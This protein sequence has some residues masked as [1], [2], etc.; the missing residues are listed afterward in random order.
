MSAPTPR[1]APPATVP[2]SFQ[3][4]MVQIISDIGASG[5][6]RAV[7]RFEAPLDEGV[8][9]R[10]V[11]LLYDQEPVL[12]CR[13]DATVSPP[14]WRRHDD[15]DALA[16]VE[17]LETD[18]ET[19]ALGRD[20]GRALPAARSWP[21]AC[22]PARHRDPDGRWRHAGPDDEPCAGGRDGA[23]R[24]L[25]EDRQALYASSGRARLSARGQHGQP[26]Q[27]RL[28]AVVP[29]AR[30]SG[31]AEGGC[32]G[33]TP[34]PR[35]FLGHPQRLGELPGEAGAGAA[36]P[37][38]ASDRA[39]PVACDRPLRPRPPG[40][41]QRRADGRLL[42]RLCGDL[43]PAARRQAR[44]DGADQH[45][46][47]CAAAGGARD[48]QPRQRH[49]YDHRQR[50]R[51][52]LRGYAPPRRRGDEAAQ[53]APARDRV[54]APPAPAPPPALRVESCPD[55]Q[56]AAQ[57]AGAAEP[58]HDDQ[59]RP[60]PSGERAFRRSRA[61]HRARADGG[62]AIADLPR[63]RAPDG[64]PSGPGAGL[65]CRRA[66][67]RHSRGLLRRSSTATFAFDTFAEP[68]HHL[69]EETPS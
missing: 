29:L 31:D 34:A 20:P 27:L 49:L 66:A 1:S 38:R 41:A 4:Q 18:D 40:H 61:Q 3:D 68:A 12:A 64:Q 13:F 47:L 17:V 19:E 57:A 25:P 60:A 26:R 30:L 15:L 54:P 46:P 6:V 62:G 9:T 69:L 52:R 58:A 65:R 8:L 16:E 21:P 5:Y 48:P 10:A 7:L 50:A 67:T 42:S 36:G 28:D 22:Q 45:A 11:R 33:G 63:D 24:Q 35:P 37:S 51:R 2:T 39:R 56:G 44:A 32:G 14:V 43:S 53:A 55:R 59:C 23:P